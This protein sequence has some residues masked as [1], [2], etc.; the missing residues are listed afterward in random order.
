LSIFLCIFLYV[1]SPALSSIV[2]IYFIYFYTQ[3]HNFFPF[4]LHITS[5]ILHATTFIGGEMQWIKLRSP[6]QPQLAM[7]YILTPLVVLLEKHSHLTCGLGLSSWKRGDIE[8]FYKNWS[9]EL[10]ILKT[11]R[12]RK[13]FSINFTCLSLNQQ[14]IKIDLHIVVSL[15]PWETCFAGSIKVAKKVHFGSKFS[16]ISL[17]ILVQS[18]PQFH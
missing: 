16:T 13:T 5:Q 6:N 9:S 1:F 10:E 3:S 17:I 12:K 8:N 11:T 4:L 2:Q 7:A 15:I 18:F 14:T